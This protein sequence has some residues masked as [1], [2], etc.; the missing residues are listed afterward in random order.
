[1]QVLT[2]CAKR[3]QRTASIVCIV[4][5][6]SSSE[7]CLDNYSCIYGVKYGNS[8]VSALVAQW[9]QQT[10]SVHLF[11]SPSPLRKTP[12]TRPRTMRH[13]LPIIIFSTFPSS[14]PFQLT[15]RIFL[16]TSKNR[17]K[18]VTSRNTHSACLRIRII[19]QCHSGDAVRNNRLEQGWK[20]W[21][22]RT[23]RRNVIYFVPLSLLRF[24]NARKS[25]NRNGEES[26]Q[27]WENATEKGLTLMNAGRKGGFI[28]K[29]KFIELSAINWIIIKL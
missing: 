3:T 12:K 6:L 23:A 28:R 7:N 1:M 29:A 20:A 22:P 24:M 11:F 14:P 15:S 16:V 13:P 18:I 8:F 19:E 2:N 5:I 10:I 9:K 4:D 26:E 17:K 21:C 25:L 27:L